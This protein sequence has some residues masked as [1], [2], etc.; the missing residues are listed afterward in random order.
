MTPHVYN[1]PIAAV[2]TPPPPYWERVDGGEAAIVEFVASGEL[3]HVP[4]PEN[5][6]I[7]EG[8]MSLGDVDWQDEDVPSVILGQSI[9]AYARKNPVILWD[10]KR[11]FPIGQLLEWEVSEKGVFVRFRILDASDFD[12]PDSEILK[13]CNEVWGLVRRGLVRGLSWDGRAR[14][15][16][17]WSTELGKL[18]KQPVEILMSEITVTPV[19]V[20]PGAKITGVNTL[21][22]A[23]T[24]CKALELGD[25]GETSMSEELKAAQDAY[26]AALHKMPDGSTLPPEILNNHEQITKALSLEPAPPPPQEPPPKA[27]TTLP[28]ELQEAITKALEPLQQKV[29][30][31]ESKL[32]VPAELRNKVQHGNAPASNPRPGSEPTPGEQFH[33]QITKALQLG[34]QVRDGKLQ[35]GHG[36]RVSVN[37]EDLMGACMI[38]QGLQLNWR[39]KGYRPDI[40]LPTL[41][42]LMERATAQ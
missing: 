3:Y 8:W 17:I 25:K 14:K 38:A 39:E 5:R 7:A 34:S 30:D 27:S 31:L 20:H 37:G 41:Q 12:D 13:K 36:E 28:S 11:H 16:Y 24:L 19:Q 2:E 23:L 21:S 10:H 9:A 26:L 22:K 1:P 40:T 33:E 15:R 6:R 32:N 35:R 42:P 18:I 4:D 29:G